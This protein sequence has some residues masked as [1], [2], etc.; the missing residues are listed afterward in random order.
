MKRDADQYTAT[1]EVVMK[2]LG[3]LMSSIYVATGM[4]VLFRS[5]ELFNIPQPFI[6]PLGIGLMSYGIFRGY[7]L[8]QKYFKKRS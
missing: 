4:M 3:L 2:Y 1:F 8:S 5:R 7:R 6:I